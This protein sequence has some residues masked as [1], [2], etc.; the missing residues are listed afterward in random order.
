MSHF[1]RYFELV[2]T[3]AWAS[4]TP[5]ISATIEDQ[6]NTAIESAAVIFYRRCPRRIGAARQEVASGCG[7]SM[8]RL[9][10]GQ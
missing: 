1:D 6:I 8:C 4:K 9:S 7:M 10:G 5:T 3:G 2:D